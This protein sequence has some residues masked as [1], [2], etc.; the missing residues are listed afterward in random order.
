MSSQILQKVLCLKR[1]ELEHDFEVQWCALTADDGKTVRFDIAPQGIFHSFFFIFLYSVCVKK[2]L[3]EMS[4][5]GEGVKC[6]DGSFNQR[7]IVKYFTDKQ[8]I[9]KI[10]NI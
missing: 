6:S 7:K 10:L 2:I 8:L 9:H 3:L 5:N 4:V 1:R